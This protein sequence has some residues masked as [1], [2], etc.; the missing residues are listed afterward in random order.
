MSGS[1]HTLMKATHQRV[2]RRHRATYGANARFVS[3]LSDLDAN[4]AVLAG[5]QDGWFNSSTFDDQVSLFLAG[6]YVQM[7]LRLETVRARAART[8]TLLP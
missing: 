8:M 3:D 6:D 4:Y 2:S 7:P 5:G 1:I